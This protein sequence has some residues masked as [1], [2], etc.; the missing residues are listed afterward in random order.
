MKTPKDFT[1]TGDVGLYIDP[2]NF[3]EELDKGLGDGPLTLGIFCTKCNAQYELGR[4][5]AAMAMITNC[6]FAEYLR[7]VQSSSCI[8]CGNKD[9][10]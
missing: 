10:H 8:K 3:I 5:G 2:E 6:S 7:W 9:D 1:N 4:E